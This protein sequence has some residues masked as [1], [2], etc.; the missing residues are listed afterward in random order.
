MIRIFRK[1]PVLLF[2]AFLIGITSRSQA[3]SIQQRYA[4]AENLYTSKRAHAADSVFQF[5][6]TNALFREKTTLAAQTL[7]LRSKILLSLRRFKSACDYASRA[8]DVFTQINDLDQLR[9]AYLSQANCYSS[10]GKNEQALS[11][12]DKAITIDS[13]RNLPKKL[14]YDYWK[15]ASIYVTSGDTKM[16]LLYLEKDIALA[17]SAGLLEE[18]QEAL[19][20]MGRIYM[21]VGEFESSDLY[22][23]RAQSIAKRRDDR[24]SMS[25]IHYRKSILYKKWGKPDLAEEQNIE[26]RLLCDSVKQPRYYTTLIIQAANLA[27][28]DNQLEKA[29]RF[30]AW[31]FNR[32]KK[33]PYPQG[34]SRYYLLKAR[35]S[36]AQKDYSE[37]NYWVD[38]SLFFAK[39]FFDPLI[40][41]Q[42]YH[43]KSMIALLL[44]DE[45]AHLKYRALGDDIQDAVMGMDNLRAVLDHE[46]ASAEKE[47]AKEVGQLNN[48]L[49]KADK[50]HSATRSLVFG[51]LALLCV[52][53]IVSAYFRK[54]NRDRKKA[55]KQQN[56]AIKKELEEKEQ[57]LD[58]IAKSGVPTRLPLP[59][60]FEP[61]SKREKDVFRLLVDNHSDKE[62]ADQLCIS[63]P[64]VRTHV[65][66]IFEKFHLNSR[67]EAKDIHLKYNVLDS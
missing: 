1:F 8:I 28:D 30:G 51:M 20:F 61:L 45:A 63:L 62:I 58:E 39:N 12:C 33:S 59:A 17:S 66:H 14:T 21:N 38:S 49:K 11:A 50:K 6:D 42:V 44:G 64:T 23:N 60:H 10:Q 47:R 40:R 65:R 56:E 13:E 53:I 54:R 37:A 41:V 31:S 57:S 25:F 48:Q 52:V 5:I 43:Q 19:L 27:L 16:A 32:L 35:I 24:P 26:A 36:T 55:L 7:H 22:M 2:I 9:D 3:Q 4:E 34:M 15:K 46:M 29:A 67:M 18:Q